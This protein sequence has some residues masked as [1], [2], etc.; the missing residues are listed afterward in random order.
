VTKKTLFEKYG[1]Y[2]T[3][4]KLVTIFYDT[5]LADDALANY[6]ED[7][8]M[9]RLI[10]HQTAFVGMVLGGPASQYTGR[11]LKTAHAQL[12]ITQESF[13]RVAQHMQSA[14]ETCK[15]EGEDIKAIMA[16]VASTQ[17]D[18]VTQ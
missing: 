12:K 16:I 7:V 8:D 3:V 14:L 17:G 18:I 15:V 4:S 9:E 13:N 2:E 1:G 11:D 6:F 10:K 5:V